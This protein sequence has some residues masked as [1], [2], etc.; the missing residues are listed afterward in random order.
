MSIRVKTFINNPVSSNCHIIYDSLKKCGLVIDPGSQDSSNILSFIKNNDIKVDYVIITHEH[1]DHTWSADKLNATVLCSK[2]CKEN[3]KD[4]KRNLSFYFN[5][6]G[7]DLNVETL[8]IEEI[9][10]LLSWNNLNIS[11]YKNGAHSPGGLI[12][13]IDRFLITGDMLIKDLRTVTKLKWAKKEEL[14][15][16]VEWLDKRKGENLLVLSGHGDSFELDDYDLNKMF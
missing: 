8:C 10:C 5:Q 13:V 4:K 16:A 7:F 9:D 2:E 15:D 12:F 11:F 14:T 1:F 3:M 6:T